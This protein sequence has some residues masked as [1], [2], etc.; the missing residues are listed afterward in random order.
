VLQT[1]PAARSRRGRRFGETS[2]LQLPEEK[3]HARALGVV[4]FIVAVVA[5]I[6]LYL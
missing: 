5:A 1:V 3:S 4:L 6:Y 2:S